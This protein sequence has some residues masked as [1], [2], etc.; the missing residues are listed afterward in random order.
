MGG[1]RDLPDPQAGVV[2]L[3]GMDETAQLAADQVSLGDDRD[4]R[5]SQVLAQLDTRDLDL[6]VEQA[7]A[8]VKSAQAK[9]DATQHGAATAEDLA[10]TVDAVK[11]LDR[12][13]M[14][15]K[16]DV[17][18][19]AQLRAVVDAGVAQFTAARRWPWMRR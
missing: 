14:A 9:L 1:P 4:H 3:L 19:R 8:N 2:R 6:A 13:I 7:A 16:A 15:E 12:R 17:R 11:A 5:R 10:E 18:E